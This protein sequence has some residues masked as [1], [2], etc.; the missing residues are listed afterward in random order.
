MKFI[1]SYE[2]KLFLISSLLIL[3]KYLVSYYFYFDEDLFFKIFRLARTDFDTYSLIIESLSRF[4]L[5]TD[6][7]SNLNSEKIIGFP[8]FSL[9]LHSILFNFFQYYSFICLEIFFYFLLILL[10]FKIFFLIQKNKQLSFIT[11]VIL[12]LSLDVLH[13]LIDFTDVNFFVVLL[14]LAEFYGFRLPH[15]LVT[16]VYFFIIFLMSIK[17]FQS[18]NIKLNKKYFLIIGFFSILLINS[19]FFHFI[20]STIF[21]LFLAVYKFRKSLLEMIKINIKS[22]I[23]LFILIFIGFFILFTQLHFAEDDYSSRLGTYSIN[24]ND[25]IIITKILLKKLIQPEII[26]LIIL[27]TLAKLNY[28]NFGIFGEDTFNY[29]ILLLFFIACLVSPFVFVIFTNTSIYLYYFWSAVKFSSFLYIFL[30]LM[31]I[32]TIEKLRLKLNFLSIFFVVLMFTLNIYNNFNKQKNLDYEILKNRDE[33]KKYLISN[34]HL[35]SDKILLSNDYPIMHLWL[36]FGNDNLINTHGFVSSYSDE[37]LED[38]KMNYFKILNLSP[39]VFKNIITENENIEFSRNIFA[40][41]FGYKYSVNLI[42]HEKPIIDEYPKNL[43]DQILKISPLVQWH[44]FFSNSE[45][46]RLIKKYTELKIN[47]KF[48]PNLMIMKKNKLLM[49]NIQNVKNSGYIK[50]FENQNFII[51]QKNI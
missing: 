23:Y 34:N 6:W 32:F 18:K 43:R 9:I 31:K 44:Q 37:I 10:F 2:F 39:E 38:L 46:K 35:N 50:V 48:M 22:F 25:K 8:F 36:K 5:K 20:K 51:L 27:I 21:L 33:I 13:F 15:P 24:I 12:F 4:D 41:S 28:K 14:P 49:S 30:I 26:V 29:D 42:R 40:H 7:L 45:K 11:T 1:N 16:S 17:L 3:I 19:F 47:K